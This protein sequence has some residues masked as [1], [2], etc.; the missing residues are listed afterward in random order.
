MV[1]SSP[2]PEE[3]ADAAERAA[4]ADATVL[5]L[6]DAHLYA[7]NRALL[8]ALQ[9]RARRAGR[10]AAARSLR[11]RAARAGRARAHRLRLARL[12]DRRGG[13]SP[14]PPVS[15][16]PAQRLVVY[17]PFRSIFY[18]PQFV[19]LYGGHFAAEGFDVEVRTAGGGVTSAGALVDGAAKVSL[20]GVMRSL[21]LVD[22]GGP[23]LVHFA[24]VN[25]RNGFF[26]LSRQP[27]PRFSWSAA[28]RQD[29]AVVRGGADP[30]AVH[31]HGVAHATA[32]IRP[33][34]G[35][36]APCPSPRRSPRSRPVAADFLE[37]G[38]PFAEI[39]LAEGAAHLAASMGEATGPLPFSSYMTTTEF[40]RTERDT[41]T[42]FTR[43]LYRA[44]RWLARASAAEVARS[45]RA[46]VRRRRPRRSGVAVVA[47]Y[48]AQSTWA[49]DPILRQPGYE[50]LQQILLDGGFIK[51]RHRY[52]DLID[53]SIAQGGRQRRLSA[54]RSSDQPIVPTVPTITSHDQREARAPSS[55]RG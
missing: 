28:R 50:Y 38:Q 53:T 41:L 48:L 21:D 23:R 18:A 1:A 16:R 27:A 47:R 17:E 39:L 22:Q 35:S 6:Y 30:V 2:R 19:T 54:V 11:R 15:R 49:A 55:R 25:S 52:E 13:R 42:R 8:E 45:D 44:Q 43:A 34:C 24:E 20:G 33:R 7:S 37:T 36:S 12:P 10:R 26:L 31:A 14:D 4:A 40:L 32:S 9:A 3:I 46:G 5:F 51:R 29:R